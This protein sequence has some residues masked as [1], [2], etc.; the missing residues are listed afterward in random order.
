METDT[1]I[2]SPRPFSE[3]PGLW[4]KLFRMDVAFFASEAPR[5]SGRNTLLAVLIYAVAAFIFASIEVLFTKTNFGFCVPPAQFVLVWFAF[6]A[7]IGIVHLCAKLFGGKGSFTALAYL[8]SLFVVPL[9][10]LSGLLSLIPSP[11][12]TYI[13]LAVT[14]VYN[15]IL[16]V[17]AIKVTYQ[18][19]TGRAAAAYLTPFSVLIIFSICMIGILALLGPSVGTIFSNVI[20]GMGTPAP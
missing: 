18:L 4:L 2:V 8:A 7:N 15:I 14:M 10:I 16:M 5:V 3:I 12:I 17:R 13:I 20:Q 11:A 19:S 1:N 6:Y 9:G